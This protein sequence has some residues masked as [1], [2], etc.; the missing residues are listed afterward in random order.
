MPES[1][2]STT[3]SVRSEMPSGPG[4]PKARQRSSSA[5][6]RALASSLRSS[7]ASRIAAS[8]RQVPNA[9]VRISHS[10][11]RRPQSNRSSSAS[12]GCCKSRSQASTCLEVAEV[13]GRR[14]LGPNL[15]ENIVCFGSPAPREQNVYQR[16]A[17][18]REKTRHTGVLERA[19]CIRL[20]VGQRSTAQAGVGTQLSRHRERRQRPVLLRPL[21]HLGADPHL[22]VISVREDEHERRDPEPARLGTRILEQSP[23]SKRLQGQITCIGRRSRSSG[24][25]RRDS[26][27][28]ALPDRPRCAG[29]DDEPLPRRLETTPDGNAAPRGCPSR[30]L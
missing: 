17:A 3:P 2:C 20:R 8:A 12:S 7:D 28:Q 16:Y 13:A 19:Q 26:D 18:E 4:A 5:R 11:S 6:A 10:S 14:G 25:V 29:C 22:V 23:I 24:V 9:G 30:R 15:R 21:D 1:P 27:L